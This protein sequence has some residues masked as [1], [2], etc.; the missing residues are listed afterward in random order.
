M[1]L[2]AWPQERTRMPDKDVYPRPETPPDPA[3]QPA[4]GEKPMRTPSAR[5]TKIVRISAAIVLAIGIAAVG[6]AK[7]LKEEPARDVPVD[8]GALVQVQELK[9]GS[10][11]LI[12]RAQGS[13]IPAK[14]ITVHAEVSGRIEWVSPELVPGGRL[15]KGAELV[16]IDARDYRLRLDQAK[17]SLEQARYQ[18]QIEVARKAVAEREWSMI[19]SDSTSPAGKAVALREP[20]LKA[21]EARVEAAESAAELAQ[22]QLARSTI[23]AP[24]A[25]FIQMESAD[26]GQFVSPQQPIATLVGTNEFWVQVSVPMDDLARIQVPGWNTK[27]GDGSKAEVWSELGGE[28]VERSGVVTG[29]F[30]ELD[31]V[32]RMA[33]LLVTIEDPFDLAAKKN[34]D[35]KAPMPLLLG[36]YVNVEINTGVE[37]GLVEVPRAAV[38]EGNKVY[39]YGANN[40]LELRDVDI[41]WSRPTSLL[42]R[43]GVKAGDVVIVSRIPSPLPGMKLR[44]AGPLGLLAPP[45]ESRAAAARPLP[46]PNVAVVR[47]VPAAGTSKD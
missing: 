27:A 18:L 19:G 30:G 5:D 38:F 43:S 11:E 16:R 36:S 1:R 28:R 12:V 7:M 26:V 34:P 24:F 39:L 2:R 46:Q 23:R 40:T 4:I 31:P 35:G 42:V 29:L 47:D 25:S 3:S 37:T 41:A 6:A 22:V 14:Q 17:A 15:K 33:R 8:E 44:K 45:T 32:G 10:Q 21:A 9:A 20:Q 13:V